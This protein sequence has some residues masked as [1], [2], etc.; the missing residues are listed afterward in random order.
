[1]KVNN[2]ILAVLVLV[3]SIVSVS[4]YSADEDNIPGTGINVSIHR[5]SALKGSKDL[6]EQARELVKSFDDQSTPLLNESGDFLSRN[7]ETL[8]KVFSSTGPVAIM[9]PGGRSPVVFD[10]TNGKFNGAVKPSDVKK[11]LNEAI[12]NTH[13]EIVRQE[14]VLGENKKQIADALGVIKSNAHRL[15]HSEKQSLIEHLAKELNVERAPAASTESSDCKLDNTVLAKY[16]DDK[17][18]ALLESGAMCGKKAE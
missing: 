2:K 15:N 13:N 11:A 14:R 6:M 4:G 7:K 5:V 1:M 17:L 9:S 12:T 8:E 18:S 3:F 16:L 10:K